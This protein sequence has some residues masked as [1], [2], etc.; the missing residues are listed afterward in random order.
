MIDIGENQ[1]ILVVAA[2]NCK[3]I[4]KEDKI[5]NEVL[6]Y[7]KKLLPVET[8]NEIYM[9]TTQE[10]LQEFDYLGEEKAYKIVIENTNLLAEKCDK[11]NP[12]VTGKYYP[13]I[14]NSKQIIKDETYKKVHEIYGEKLPEN[15]ESRLKLELD[16]ITK[17]DYEIMY[18]IAS[19]LVKKSNEYGYLVGIRGGVGDSF[20]AYLLGITEFNP[21]E[22]NLPF[23]IFAGKDYDKEPDIDLNFAP[24]I[25]EKLNNYLKEKFGKDKILYCGI[26][27]TLAEKTVNDAIN[28]YIEEFELSIDENEKQRIVN[29]LV[30]IK[31]RDGIH[32]GGIIILPEDKEITDFTPIEKNDYDGKIKTQIDYH[33]LDMNLYKF[34]ILSSKTQTILQQ[35]QETTGVN[36]CN[37]KLDDKETLELFLNEK[38]TTKG[39]PEFDTESAVNMLKKTKS[40]NFNDL[41][42]IDAIQHGTGTWT[43]NA[44]HIIND[45][46]AK[47]DELVSNREDLMNYLE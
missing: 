36:P 33:S 38:N 5:C 29:K 2:S 13:K 9:H 42:C 17:N 30:G 22:Y 26:V 10:M 32:P 46:E 6:N 16:T 28:K 18:L 4:N 35:L 39:I 41:V 11:I 37:I 1:N 7:Y 31:K 34:D 12:I 43:Y 47:V 45:K 24:K 15:V 23:E 21:I 14:Q 19:E 20:V 8:D 40:Q 27:G 25:R 3:F 44:E